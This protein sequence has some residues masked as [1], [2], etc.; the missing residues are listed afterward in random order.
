MGKINEIFELVKHIFHDDEEYFHI[1][2]QLFI[3]YFYNG[4]FNN[5]RPI[6][7]LESDLKRIIKDISSRESSG[8]TEG[9]QSYSLNVKMRNFNPPSDF[10]VNLFKDTAYLSSYEVLY[11]EIDKVNKLA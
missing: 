3:Q 6:L 11:S 8:K 7:E 5:N 1:I 2:P 4:T 9:G 10:K